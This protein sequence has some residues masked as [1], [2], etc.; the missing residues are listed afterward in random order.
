MKNPLKELVESKRFKE[1][2]PYKQKQQYYKLKS[3]LGRRIS[4][5]PTKIK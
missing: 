3:K 1:L 2:E 5:Q 4:P